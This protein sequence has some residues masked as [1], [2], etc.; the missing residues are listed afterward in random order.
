MSLH[1]VLII[2]DYCWKCT[3]TLELKRNTIFLPAL[4]KLALWPLEWSHHVQ[5]SDLSPRKTDAICISP[6]CST[7][8][9]FDVRVKEPIAIVEKTERLFFPDR[10]YRRSTLSPESQDNQPVARNIG[11]MRCFY[12]T[13][14]SS[15]NRGSRIRWTIGILCKANW[16]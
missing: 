10:N 12:H 6:V 7:W 8:Q 15:S 5:Q 2:V 11:Q 13:F 3:Y 9:P 1:S 16:E 14:R 4:Q